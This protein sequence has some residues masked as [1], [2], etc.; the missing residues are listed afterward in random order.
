MDEIKSM[1]IRTAVENM[2][3]KGHFSISTINDVLKITGGVAPRDIFNT[4]ALLH[5]IDFKDMPPALLAKLPG[6]VGECICAP[7][8]DI[9]AAFT[10]AHPG[11]ARAALT[12]GKRVF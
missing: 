7:A 2:F 6:M 3:R 5:C 8:I 10:L 9:E 4:L 11:L 12:D 1:A